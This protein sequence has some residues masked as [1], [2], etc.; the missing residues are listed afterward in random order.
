MKKISRVIAMLMAVLMMVLVIP[1]ESYA[2]AQPT[3]TFDVDSKN[4]KAISGSTVY[5]DFIINRQYA[6]EVYVVNVYKGK[7]TNEA[8]L[9]GEGYGEVDVN[10]S[11]VSL[12]LSFNTAEW[13]LSAGTVCT[14][15]CAILYYS[16]NQWNIGPIQTTTLEIIKNTCGGSHS[17]GAPR[18]KTAPTC[19]EKGFGIATCSKCGVKKRM[20][21]ANT[22]HT[23]DAGRVTREPACD[24]EGIRTYTCKNCGTTKTESISKKAHNYVAGNVI[25]P[26]TC[27]T[28]G[29]RY[30]VCSKCGASKTGTIPKGHDWDD[31]TIIDYPTVSEKGMRAC[32]CK[33]CGEPGDV[34]IP[35]IFSDVYKDWY[36]DYVQYVYD[37]TLM[38]GIKGTTKF[39]PNSNITKAQVAQV[40]YNMASQPAVTDQSVFTELKDVYRAEWYANAV[41][42]AYNNGI[43]TG[44]L[45]SKKFNPNADVTREQLAIM[46]YRFAQYQGFDTTQSSELAGLK[47]AENTANWAMDGVKWAVGAGLISG[48]EKNGIKDLAPQGNASRGQVAAILQRFCSAYEVSA[49]ETTV[50]KVV[51]FTT[52]PEIPEEVVESED[53]AATEEVVEIEDMVENEEPQVTKLPVITGELVMVNGDK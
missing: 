44:D 48:I 28:N 8:N 19:T 22:G 27:T 21:L 42:W 41:A 45:N 4:M 14:V 24:R 38:T 20:D 46:I 49:A 9:I 47:N 31:G 33:A 2:A 6:D 25:T 23:Y 35:A 53:A 17:Y 26:P 11:Q 12:T 39:Q 36:T 5:M 51:T 34:E 50:E 1:T 29:E 52:V 18:V 7:N 32:I 15:E 40:L 37:N 10:S 13:G 30:Y 43:V 16:N 3:I